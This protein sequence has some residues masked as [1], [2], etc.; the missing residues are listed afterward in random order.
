MRRSSRCPLDSQ[1][2]AGAYSNWQLFG[3]TF[4]SPKTDGQCYGRSIGTWAEKV[5]AQH[6]DAG[7][8]VRKTLGREDPRNIGWIYADDENGSTRGTSRRVVLRVRVRSR[9]PVSL[10][11]GIA[12]DGDV[13]ICLEMPVET[14]LVSFAAFLLLAIAIARVVLH[15]VSNLVSDFRK[16]KK[17]LKRRGVDNQLDA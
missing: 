2:P 15:D 5:E 9:Q 17:R 3:N 1:A 10:A 4:P 14:T 12:T 11:T 16:L 7:E 8:L 6:H 13:A